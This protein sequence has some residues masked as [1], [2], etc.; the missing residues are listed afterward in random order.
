MFRFRLT[1]SSLLINRLTLQIMKYLSLYKSSL[2]L[3]SSQNFSQ[4][5]FYLFFFLLKCLDF[6]QPPFELF[7][8]FFVPLNITGQ[9]KN[10]V[11]LNILKFNILLL[12]LLTL[13][14][15]IYALSKVLQSFFLRPYVE[16]LESLYHHH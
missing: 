14:F 13:T 1:T 10:F 4:L 7:S 12:L 16:P 8:S 6:M 9:K 15:S 11:D 3:I 5:L 2:L